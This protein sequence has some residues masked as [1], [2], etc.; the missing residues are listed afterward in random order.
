MDQWLLISGGNHEPVQ[1]DDHRIVGHMPVP[2]CEP[3][4]FNP[5]DWH[6]YLQVAQQLE[7]DNDN[8]AIIHR[9]ADKV[10]WFIVPKR[11]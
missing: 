5:A 11:A 8:C 6:R 1:A 2:R 3:E 9:A 4:R 7:R 10:E